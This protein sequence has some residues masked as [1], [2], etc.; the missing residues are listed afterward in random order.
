M[1]AAHHLSPLNSSLPICLFPR[2]F[3]CSSVIT[4]WSGSSLA[5]ATKMSR[6]R[7]KAKWIT[8]VEA[9]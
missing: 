6:V 2:L 7:G 4:S 1:N 8:F 9:F 3:L 5:N